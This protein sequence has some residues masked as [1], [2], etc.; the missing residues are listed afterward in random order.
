M[1]TP[2]YTCERTR[3]KSEKNNFDAMYVIKSS[4]EPDHSWRY[5]S[6][7]LSNGVEEKRKTEYL[8]TRLW[9]VDDRILKLSSLL[10][11]NSERKINCTVFIWVRKI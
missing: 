6:K 2:M 3:L 11:E 10:Y 7:I 4:Q 5:H 1:K 9:K 8:S